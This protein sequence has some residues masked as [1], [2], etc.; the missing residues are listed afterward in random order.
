MVVAMNLETGAVRTVG[1]YAREQVHGIGLH[2]ATGLGVALEKNE[3]AVRVL[4]V[5]GRSS[6]VDPAR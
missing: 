6:F 1:R 3:K 2:V 5:P 4:G